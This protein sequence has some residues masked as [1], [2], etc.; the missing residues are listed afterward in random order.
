[1]DEKPE[2]VDVKAG[3]LVV[4]IIRR[5]ATC[6]ACKAELQSGSMLHIGEQR[7]SL[8][9]HCAKL[10]DLEFLPRGDVALTRR[11]SKHSTRRAIV[12]EWSR[13]RKRYERQGTLVVGGAIRRAQEEC[14]LDAVQRARKRSLAA[15]QR[16]LSD[17][18]YIELFAKAV[19]SQF[20][21][22]PAGVEQTIAQHACEKHSGRVGRS[23][24]A[25][26]LDP[27]KVKL[28]VIAHVR[29]LHTDYDKLITKYGDKQMARD[30]IQDRMRQVIEQW[31]GQYARE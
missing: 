13:R 6:D 24:S 26:A 15:E 7:R 17:Q 11:A 22:A 28:A 30:A 4:F 3:E 2:L 8:C 23:A 19:R 20:P 1:M 14:E 27:Q 9:L 18:A 16:K 21:S 5:A 29:H 25:K 12:V 31:G 10:A